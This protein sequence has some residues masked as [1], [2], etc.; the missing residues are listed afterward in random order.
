MYTI[1]SKLEEVYN[2][3]KRKGLR[4]NYWVWT[5]NGEELQMYQR[6]VIHNKVQAVDHIEYE[7]KTNLMV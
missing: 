4:E 3:L 5:S 2:H 1:I 6:L 7:E